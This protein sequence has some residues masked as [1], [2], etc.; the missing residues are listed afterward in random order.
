MCLP[1][2]VLNRVKCDHEFLAEAITI[3][4]TTSKIAPS[5][6][7]LSS[8]VT[9]PPKS[10]TIYLTTPAQH[11]ADEGSPP[12]HFPNILKSFLT[13]QY[14]P[15]KEEYPMICQELTS[16]VILRHCFY[17]G[18]LVAGNGVGIR[19]IDVDETS[20]GLGP[21]DYRFQRSTIGQEG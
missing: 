6:E 14:I 8:P 17:N 5:V 18:L 20:Q 2:S 9:N 3:P 19:C 21:I 13:L 11:T 10:I 16:R 7:L 1:P 4:P 15:V 12:L